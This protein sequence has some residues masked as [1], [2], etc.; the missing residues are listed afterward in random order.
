MVSK[1]EREIEEQY[2]DRVL[3]LVGSQLTDR[4]EQLRISKSSLYG[5][6][7]QGFSAEIAGAWAV[8]NADK[9]A[10]TLEQQ[11]AIPYFG[12]IDFLED[13][14]NDDKEVYY[15]GKASV[16]DGN[17]LV[18]VDWRAPVASMYYSHGLGTAGYS[19]PSGYIHGEILLKRQYVFSGKSLNQIQETGS[20]SDGQEEA[21]DELLLSA[22]QRNATAQMRQIVQ[23]I[24]KEQDQ[25][26]RSSGH[27]VVV[28]GPAGSGK[29]IIALH[30]AAYL[31]YQMREGRGRFSAQGN[32]IS[33][34]RMLVFSPNAIF[35]RYISSVLPDLQEDGIRQ[36]ILDS[37]INGELGR[38]LLGGKPFAIEQKEDHYE[39]MLS[40]ATEPNYAHRASSSILKS[41]ASMIDFIRGYSEYLDEEIEIH[42]QDVALS[43]EYTDADVVI[44][45]RQELLD[46][47]KMQRGQHGT[48]II[49][50]LNDVIKYL[51]DDQ[52]RIEG[53]LKQVEK[54]QRRQSFLNERQLER[55]LPPLRLEITRLTKIVS[56]QQ[57][58]KLS[59]QYLAML[60]QRDPGKS[61]LFEN[62]GDSIRKLTEDAFSRHQVLYED[63]LPLL[64]LD[65]F[66]RGFTPLGGL[67]HAIVDEAQDYSLLHFEYIK[68]C[69]PASCSMT[70]VGDINQATNPQLN[71]QSYSNL[72]AVYSSGIKQMELTRSYRSSCEITS[73]ASRILGDLHIDNVRRTGQKPVL[74]K[75]GEQN[76]MQS[77]VLSYIRRHTA[78]GA[79]TVA[80][81]CKTRTDCEAIHPYLE[82]QV[83]AKRLTASSE[84]LSAE[85]VVL[86]IY[87]AK[88]LE[89][90]AVI[91]PDADAGKYGK[92]S[93]RRLLYTA[94]TRALHELTL[95]CVGRPSPLLPL[96]RHD[97]YDPVAWVSEHLHTATEVGAVAPALVS[98]PKTVVE[99]MAQ[100]TNQEFLPSKERTELGCKIN[101]RREKLDTLINCFDNCSHP[102]A[103]DQCEGHLISAMLKQDR[104]EQLYQSNCTFSRLKLE[105]A[106]CRNWDE[107]YFSMLDELLLQ[108]AHI[109]ADKNTEGQ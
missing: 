14:W 1:I 75:V 80:V 79:K 98:A 21:V 100:Q 13:D 99:V 51:K 103:V 71:L 84:D 83:G 18:V 2:L 70:I 30:R 96:E 52:Q 109:K 3:M 45:S 8:T 89:F 86:P 50:R 61:G 4:R 38:R 23:S 54:Q 73:F 68:N 65:G 93:E 94:C 101:V 107:M 24:Q 34:Q 72:E 43:G 12:R 62:V 105:V 108:D 19:A 82:N 67:N 46:R 57:Q 81:L 95:L 33:A 35:S 17:T 29:T 74:V 20:M 106:S 66:Y 78:A 56:E 9:A 36:I 58:I 49:S 97:L 5:A 31:L 28:Q 48:S 69:L 60:Q 55:L 44:H 59:D 102:Q 41:S 32:Q 22:L 63:A 92:D 88:G 104:L 40:A 11:Q 47:Y 39:Y 85:V 27:V 91:I 10:T 6:P 25:I 53:E 90:D 87:L 77:A 76:A 26:I 16:W 42:F 15:I 37:H 64:L 7:N